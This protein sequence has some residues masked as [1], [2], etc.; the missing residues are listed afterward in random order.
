MLR[1]IRFLVGENEI[2][3]E[4]TEKLRNDPKYQQFVDWCKANGLKARS[5]RVA[6]IYNNDFE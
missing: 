3:P 5:V 4:L 2:N 1:C 6:I